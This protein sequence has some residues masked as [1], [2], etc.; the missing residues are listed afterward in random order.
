MADENSYPHPGPHPDPKRQILK[1]VLVGLT[2][3]AGLYTG[4]WFF[5]S[6]QLS[7]GIDTWLAQQKKA[8]LEIRYASQ[9][10]SGFPF[11]IKITVDQPVIASDR[12]PTSF[13]WQG[14]QAMEYS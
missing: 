14:Q 5:L 13:V 7:S 4:G 2:I 11:A 10:R 9:Q 8:G 12:K 6:A 1:W 3:V